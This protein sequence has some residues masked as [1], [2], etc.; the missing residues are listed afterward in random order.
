MEYKAKPDLNRLTI[1]GRLTRDAELKYTTTGTAIANL[2]LASNQTKKVGDSWEVEGHFFD[3]VLIGK[4]A[5]A[6]QRYL[7]KGQQVG[8]DGKLQQDRWKNKEGQNRS[9]VKILVNDI[10]LLGGRPGN[11]D[12]EPA[13]GSGGNDFPDSIPF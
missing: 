9:K 7:V 11:R 12:Q 6:L 2:S 8:L 3:A 10:Q 4:R 5:E 1:V 13:G